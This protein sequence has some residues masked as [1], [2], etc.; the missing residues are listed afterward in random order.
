[1]PIKK[2]RLIVVNNIN[3]LQFNYKQSNCSNNVSILDTIMF[4]HALLNEI[5]AFIAVAEQGSFTLAAE[6]LRSSKSSTSKAIQKLE[7]ALGIK[8]FNRSTR[9]VRLTEEGA[10]YL[11]AV[12]HAIDI[13]N[14]AKLLL[15]TRKVEPT[16]RL[17]V[18]LPIAIGRVVVMAL[19]NFTQAHPKVSVEI[20]LSDRF[21]VPIV[22]DWDI[23]VRVGELDDSGLTARKLCVLS[24]VLCASPDYLARKGTPQ[25]LQDLRAQD[26]VMYRAPA[27]KIRPWVFKDNQHERIEMSPQPLAIFSESGALIDATISGLGIAQIYDKTIA[28]EISNGKLVE[29]LSETSLSGPPVHALITSG[30]AMPAKTRVFVEFLTELFGG[31]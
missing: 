26:A 19:S 14:E 30:R 31:D 21:E 20:S 9:S 13:I 29:V 2:S 16:G 8:L 28:T 27:G 22:G 1:M 10:I 4:R 25:N 3:S 6:N 12:K 18:N 11:D 7:A 15:D 17:R 23:V 24:H 5:I